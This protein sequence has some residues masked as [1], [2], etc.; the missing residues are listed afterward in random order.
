MADGAAAGGEAPASRI[1]RQALKSVSNDPILSRM[2]AEERVETRLMD[3][4]LLGRLVGYLSPHKGL[5]TASIAL[6]IGEALMMT[7][8]AYVIGLAIDRMGET[9]VRQT[10]EVAA[11]F[12]GLA[13]G[14]LARFG[15]LADGGESGAAVVFF[16][17]LVLAVSVLMWLFATV[18]TYAVQVLG[19]RVVH[20]LRVEVFGHVTGMDQEFF[21]KNPVGRLVNR[22]TFDVESVSELFSDAFAQGMRDIL[23]LIVLIVVMFGLDPVL[24]AIM[25]LSFPWLVAVSLLYRRYARPAL[26]TNSAVRSRMNAWLA[27][28]LAGM[29]ENHLYRREPRRRAEFKAL[30]VA[31]QGSIT[32]V[33]RAWGVLRPGMMIVSGISTTAVL[34]IGHS[35][36]VEGAITVGVLLTFV[37]YTIQ[38]WRP[39]RNLTEKFNLVQTAL[40]AGE[41][42][43]DVLGARAKVKDAEGAD[44]SLTVK[45]GDIEFKGVK[46]KYPSKDE[47]VLDGVS[48]SIKSGGFLALVGDT[49]A[50]KSTIAHLISRFYDVT[51]GEVLVDGVDTRRYLLERLRSGIAIVPQDVVVFA[52][53][54]RD[55][56][57]LGIEVTEARLR[58]CVEAVCADTFIDRLG[59][60]D[61]VL[62]EGG[63]TLSTGERQLLSFARA[64]VFNPPVL[65]LDEATANVDTQTEVLIQK[66]LAAL[67]KGRTSVVIA[68]RLSTVRDADQILV[69]RHGQIIERGDHEALMGQGGEYARLVRLHMRDQ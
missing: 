25:M 56:I 51:E 47:V 39:V 32:H 57:T 26:R 10:G 8:P 17:V 22:T 21:H 31:Y 44:T 33:I 63:R 3:T 28:N 14:A 36:V 20:D 49:G 41:R 12:D 38:M 18:T 37:Q 4:A 30:T 53:T 65:I 19:Q 68:H 13:D 34:L 27:E 59:G 9:R 67:T 35:R 5:A 54:V 11:F 6:A 42:I 45:R 7:V 43:F 40:T 61:H 46:F 1:E 62:E 69:L 64:L 50:G 2:L 55:N 52:G 16:G 60:L 48:F 24:A 23:F 29:R 58:S 15:P 66:A